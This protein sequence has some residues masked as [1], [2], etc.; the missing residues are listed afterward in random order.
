[1][2]AVSPTIQGLPRKNEQ[3]TKD[4][5]TTPTEETATRTTD[6]KVINGKQSTIFNLERISKF[7]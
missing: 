6:A 2:E 5:D 1:M 4:K 7:S 3:S